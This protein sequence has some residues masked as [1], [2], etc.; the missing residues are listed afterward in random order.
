MVFSSPIIIEASLGFMYLKTPRLYISP[1]SAEVNSDP[2]GIGLQACLEALPSL[3]G[4]AARTA[5]IG[6]SWNGAI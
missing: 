2:G 3:L 5:Q 6:N 1:S 4:W